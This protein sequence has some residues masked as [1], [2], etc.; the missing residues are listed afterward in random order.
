M[1]PSLLVAL[2]S[3]LLLGCGGPAEPA[4]IDRETFIETWVDLR[5][6]VLHARGV[7]TDS[8]RERVLREHGATEEDLLAFADEHGRDP[9]YMLELWTEVAERL[10]PALAPDTA[11]IPPPGVPPGS[12]AP[13]A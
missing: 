2:A 11:E 10:R 7:L 9:A 3:A 4:V 13:G 8:A 1:R 12:A 6:T 5:L